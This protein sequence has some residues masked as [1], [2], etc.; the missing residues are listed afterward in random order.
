MKHLSAFLQELFLAVLLVTLCV[1]TQIVLKQWVPGLFL[2]LFYF[3]LIACGYW[4][5]LRGAVIATFVSLGA[6]LY[7]F[8]PNHG[9]GYYT[10]AKQIIPTVVYIT[11]GIFFGMIMGRLK[12][13]NKLLNNHAL[14]LERA[15]KAKDEFISMASHE[16]KTPLTSIRVYLQILERAIKTKGNKENLQYVQVVHQQIERLTQTIGELVDATK[17]SHSVITVHKESINIGTLVEET[18]M[19]L[20]KTAPKHTL[21]IENKVRVSVMA[22]RYRLAQVFSNLITNAVKYSPKGGDIVIRLSK[23]AGNLC[24]SVTD[25]GDGIP[26][27]KINTIFERF[28][29][30]PTETT[31]RT[32]GLGLGLFITKAIITSHGGNI[33]AESKEGH[34]T[35]MSFTIP[36]K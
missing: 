23:Q 2:F 7:F 27:E 20:K 4:G 33:W 24:V 18:V 31:E 12:K 10:S 21:I 32:A 36:L 35:T 8:I 30:V 5:G 9:M 25:S 11:Q 34:G 15:Q 1:V 13:Q 3:V 22:D 29:R 17:A 28:Y 14:E 19:A 6:A 16:L 26:P